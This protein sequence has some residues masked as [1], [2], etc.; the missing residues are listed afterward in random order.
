M[1]FAATYAN[2]NNLSMKRGHSLVSFGMKL[3]LIGLHIKIIEN[4]TS[5]P[6]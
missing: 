4:I 5:V 3:K 6:N 1:V 2:Y